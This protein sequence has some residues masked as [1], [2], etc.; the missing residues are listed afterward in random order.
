MFIN[1]IEFAIGMVAGLALLYYAARWL[2]L[3]YYRASKKQGD[4]LPRDIRVRLIQDA[5]K[6]FGRMRRS[7][8]TEEQAREATATMMAAVDDD[9]L[10]L[11][12]KTHAAL[13]QEMF[14]MLKVTMK[15]YGENTSPASSPKPTS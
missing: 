4:E 15:K 10:Q 7:N 3:C 6:G 1:G 11:D 12:A 2:R 8:P 13:K 5:I 9:S 14:E